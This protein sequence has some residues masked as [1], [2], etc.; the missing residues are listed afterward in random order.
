MRVRMT[1]LAFN[2]VGHHLG[3][4]ARRSLLSIAL[5]GLLVGAAPAGAVPGEQALAGKPAVADYQGAVGRYL[6]PGESSDLAEE[7]GAATPEL[8]AGNDQNLIALGK[9]TDSPFLFALAS[10]GIV[11]LNQGTGAVNFC[12]GYTYLNTGTP[13]GKCKKL[14][15]ISSVGLAGNARID[16]TSNVHVFITN[17]VTGL[18]LEC[19]LG[20]NTSTGVPSGSCIS[21]QIQP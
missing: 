12:V 1:F 17:I 14:G 21:Q 18:V 20:H 7:Q 3:L 8:L 2:Y 6:E 16:V 19:Y 15:A 4:S 9:A 10:N 13:F 11:S 5:L